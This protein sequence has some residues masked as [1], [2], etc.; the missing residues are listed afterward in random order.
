MRAARWQILIA[1]LA[2]LAGA[3]AG[4]ILTVRDE[5]WLAALMP[6]DLAGGRGSHSTRQELRDKEI[7]APWPGFARSFVVFANVLFSTTP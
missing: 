6:A 5:A 1:S 3:L 2:I 7:F 4:F